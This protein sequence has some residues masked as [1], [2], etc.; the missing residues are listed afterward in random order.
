MSLML[1]LRAGPRVDD[2][3][4]LQYR[5]VKL[6]HRELCARI[7]QFASGMWKRGVLPGQRLGLS[8]VNPALHLIGLLGLAKVQ[9]AGV[10]IAPAQLSD[11]ERNSV[12]ALRLSGLIHDYPLEGAWA[13]SPPCATW[14]AGEIFFSPMLPDASTLVRPSMQDDPLWLLAH[15]SGT[16]GQAKTVLISQ[17]AICAGVDLGEPFLATD[18]A[19]LFLDM[20]MTWAILTALRLFRVG[21]LAVLQPPVL[22]PTAL[23]ELM[24]QEEINVLVLSADA[25]SKLASF[26][27]DYPDHVPPL[28]LSRVLIGGGPVSPLVMQA[29]NKHWRAQVVV[30]Y[31]S[32]EMGPVAIWRQ[33]SL[34]LL[35]D[36][37][38]LS[39]YA[40]VIAQVVDAQD[41]PLAAD[42]VGF[43]RLQSAAMFS[44]YLDADG[45]EPVKAPEWFYPGDLAS[46]TVDG[47]IRLQG[48]ADHVLNLGGLKLDPEQIESRLRDHPGV[49][50]AAVL[51]A[52]LGPM[53]VNVLVALVVVKSGFDR[54]IIESQAAQSLP[55]AQ[56]PRYWAIVQSLPRNSAGKIQRQAL[57]Q[58]V[59]L[60]RV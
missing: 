60:D 44:G 22:K 41:Q 15:S 29:L 16:T 20:S 2:R 31:G 9:A 19:L 50:D 32:T 14:A 54:K 58:M 7:D 59:R 30:L 38:E 45:R 53:K 56:R 12:S 47:A 28:S 33:S 6:S 37:Y 35:E 11:N 13:T 49:L 36:K 10:H 26:L 57:S 34:D 52:E 48:R 24:A 27:N 43:L 39:P 40:G 51:M 23:L 5:G 17:A 42:Q 25:A 46:L 21:G 8:M 18:R 1:F 3:L 55:L 4:V